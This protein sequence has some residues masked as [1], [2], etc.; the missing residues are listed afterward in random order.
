MEIKKK[1][2]FLID[3]QMI[4]PLLPQNSVKK[5]LSESNYGCSIKALWLWWSHENWRCSIKLLFHIKN[6][7]DA[8]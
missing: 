4:F 6:V 3:E 1:L 5:I 8:A 2:F 7:K